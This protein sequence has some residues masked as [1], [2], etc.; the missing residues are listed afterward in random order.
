MAAPAVSLVRTGL[1]RAA[2]RTA[3]SF[4]SPLSLFLCAVAAMQP[5]A[6]GCGGGGAVRLRA[7]TRTFFFSFFLR[8]RAPYEGCAWLPAGAVASLRSLGGL[9]RALFGI[10]P[11]SGETGG[12]SPK[13][14][15]PTTS[16]DSGNSP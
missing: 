2:R 12:T 1:R 4:P 6:R 13:S 8:D 7:Y 16:A 9:L 14:P 15:W 5:R 11:V 10:A 3:L